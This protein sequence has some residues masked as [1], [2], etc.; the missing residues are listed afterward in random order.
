MWCCY[1]YYGIPNEIRSDLFYIVLQ[2]YCVLT[3]Q[4][5]QKFLNKAFVQLQ[6]TEF[7]EKFHAY[8]IWK[9]KINLSCCLD[10]ETEQ[11]KI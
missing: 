9:H 5:V 11:K 4:K 2:S 8:T 10:N 1:F 6:I 3:N 7:H